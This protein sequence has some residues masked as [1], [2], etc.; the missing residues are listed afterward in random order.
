MF[1]HLVTC[2]YWEENGFIV[3]REI[4]PILELSNPG[5]QESFRVREW[6]I[7]G[8]GLGAGNGYGDGDGDGDGTSSFF[9]FGTGNGNGFGYG[10]GFKEIC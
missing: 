3:D 8:D 1:L 2:D 5:D 4:I 10:G 6:D 7:Y 9:G